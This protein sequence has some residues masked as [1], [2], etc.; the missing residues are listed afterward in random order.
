[1]VELRH[2]RYFLAVVEEN[3]FTRAAAR[4]HISQ[5]TLSQQIRALE[6]SIG[7][8]LFDRRPGGPR[9]T[10]AGRALLEPA[11]R[12][13]TIV[14]DGV[15]AAREAAREAAGDLRVGMIY[16]AAGALTQSILAAYSAAFPEV[17]LHFRAE[18]PVAAAYTALTRDEVD[19]AFTRLPLDPAQHAWH[20]LYEERR[21]VVVHERHALADAGSVALEDILPLPILAARPA[22]TPTAVSDHWLLNDFRNGLAP[23]QFVTEAWSVPEIAQT[24]AHNP[25][26]IAMCSEIARTQT[27]APGAPLRFLDVPEAGLS[28]AVIARREGD[29]RPHVTAFCRLAATVARGV[30]GTLIG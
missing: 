30:G 24:I 28:Q 14:N 3:G 11:T 23:A 16:A 5:P 17:R 27:P 9:L 7:H 15:R 29:H 4:L 20:V 6:R 25:G 2:L 18:L 22:R 12:A 8:P 1:M 19:V 13:M 21:V 10:A 26:V